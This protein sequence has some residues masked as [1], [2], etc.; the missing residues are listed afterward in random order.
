ACARGSPAGQDYVLGFLH[1]AVE[2]GGLRPTFFSP[3]GLAAPTELSRYGRI[4]CDLERLKRVGILFLKDARADSRLGYETK[5]NALLCEPDRQL[6]ARVE[7]LLDRSVEQCIGINP[8]AV[9][10]DRVFF[11][12][13]TPAYE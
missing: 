3:P 7:P 6:F 9:A 1:S 4:G 10:T 11:L 2:K 13:R 5:C 8:Y 12:D